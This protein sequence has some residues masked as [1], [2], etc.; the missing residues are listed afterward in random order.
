M[1][2]KTCGG[3]FLSKTAT[4]ATMTT[5]TMSKLVAAAAKKPT[6]AADTKEVGG[7]AAAAAASKSTSTVA[8][9][10]LTPPLNILP[11]KL[12]DVMP[13]TPPP[14]TQDIMTSEQCLDYSTPLPVGLPRLR[15]RSDN[16]V[17]QTES[18]KIIGDGIHRRI[19]D[20][21]SQQNVRD[22]AADAID[23]AE[24]NQEAGR[25]NLP[26]EAAAV[27]STSS[28]VKNE[29]TKSAEMEN[30]YYR[31][32]ALY[33]FVKYLENSLPLGIRK[34][35]NENN[36][37]EIKTP[38]D[39]L[40]TDKE[41]KKQEETTKEIF[42]GI[43]VLKEQEQNKNEIDIKAMLEERNEFIKRC[44]SDPFYTNQQF[45]QPW[46]VLSKISKVIAREI[47]ENFESD[48]SFGE[49]SYIRDFIDNEVQT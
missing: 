25:K 42:E 29:S 14:L 40:E 48:L 2:Q 19:E 31:R 49:E 22:G 20:V 5:T 7:I 35:V 21:S 1:K 8:P 38:D 44:Q 41:E 27:A 18:H 6:A 30:L 9:Q 23:R 28:P 37:N 34:H 33:T 16:F 12:D 13:P 47:V 4:I 17:S 10:P 45:P 43:S 24:D 11:I 26:V 15:H 36:S 3:A 39:I 46:K 32:N